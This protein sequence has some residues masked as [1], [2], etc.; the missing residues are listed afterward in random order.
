MAKRMILML[1]VMVAIIAGLG[2]VKV[3]QIQTAMAQGAAF[4]MPPEAVTTIVA[5]G[6]PRRRSAIAGRAMT[7]SPSQLGATMMRRF[8]VVLARPRWG[9][10]VCASR[11]ARVFAGDA[12]LLI[13]SEFAV[14]RPL[15]YVGVTS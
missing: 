10:R 3:K 2:V 6:S 8:T 5:S 1:V 14:S 4:Q 7:A 9:D 15:W 13:V 11:C 12:S